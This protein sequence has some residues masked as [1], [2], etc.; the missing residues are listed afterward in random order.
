MTRTLLW[1][2]RAGGACSGWRGALPVLVAA[3]LA[4]P[5]PGGRAA[6]QALVPGG[7]FDICDN[8][9]TLVGN[10][11]FLVGRPGFGTT[12]GQFVLVNAATSD[13]D[14][15]RDGYTPN[16]DFNFLRVTQVADFVSI[17][18]PAR[19]ILG[20]NLVLQDVP[21]PLRNGNQNT[22]GFLVN[23]P[24]GT[25]AGRY[26][27]S[28]TLQDSL[29]QPG[30]GP[31]G[32]A[33]RVDR[34]FIEVEVLPTRDFTLVRADTAARA[35]SLTL[36]GRA[37]QTV[38]GV[39][40][41][42]NIGNVDLTNARPEATDL[43]ATSGTGLQ[44]PRSAISFSPTS[45]SN[46]AFGDTTRLVV[47]VRIPGGILAGSYVGELIIQGDGVN[48]RRIPLTVIVTT[49]GDIVFE[50]NPVV[51]RRG[52]QA[53]IIFNADPNTTYDLAIFDM[54]GLTV[55]R[56]R[57]TVF[58]GTTSD[59]VTFAGD[60]AIRYSWNLQNGRG[61][62]VAGGMYYV[63]ADVQQDGRRRQI[64]NKLMVIR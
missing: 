53:V 6:A 1:P 51:G 33:L 22:V 28:V 15:D 17:E 37:G 52:D 23:I 62:Q 40:R 7:D 25:Q 8:M 50:T 61:E 34:F 46:V 24:G 57:G 30:I 39:V 55:F 49:P 14:C 4:V 29:L 32:E 10:T 2:G 20:T 16:V 42:A 36:R 31:N 3:L 35:D 12:V 5:A 43:V 63:V 21:R 54:I 60:E 11:A 18:D 56:T 58:G 27:G 19:V 13:Q 48:E 45:F 41:L 59:G 26:R 47:S 9:G 64:R 38:S 44:I